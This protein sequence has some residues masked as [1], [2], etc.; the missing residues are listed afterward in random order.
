MRDLQREFDSLGPWFTRFEVDGAVYGGVNS[1]EGDGRLALF[2]QW[3]GQPA[4]ILELS[5]FEGGHSVQLAA[6]SFVERLVGLEGR[7]ESIAKSL[8][9]ESILGRGN[10]EFIEADLDRDPLT[11]FGRF[12]AVFCAGLLYHLTQPWRLLEE[13][14][15]VTDRLFLDT[16]YAATVETTVDGYEGKYFGEGG[17][18]DPLSGLSPTS[19]WMTLPELESTLGKHGLV[20]TER[21]NHA[22]WGGHGP[23]VVLAAVRQ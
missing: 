3:L 19:F 14:A 22:D 12:D 11:P 20:V 9:I 1:Y 16:H 2:W 15:K 6:P 7:K 13:I 23:R 5:S 8:L 4:T 18:S 17:Y 21:H 10:V